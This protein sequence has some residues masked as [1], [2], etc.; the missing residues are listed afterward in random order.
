M[1][2]FSFRL[3]TV[4]EHAHEVE[5]E[6]QLHLARL[7]QQ[8]QRIEERMQIVNLKRE[9]L[10]GAMARIQRNRF[11]AREVAECHLCLEQQGNILVGLKQESDQIDRGINV[12]RQALLEAIKHRQMMEKLREKHLQIHRQAVEKYEL[13]TMEEATV[14]RIARE[15]QARAR[16]SESA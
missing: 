9:E 6:R 3:Q 4:L 11:D 13:K 2:A 7:C 1:K 10:L 14:P 5:E 8:K 15:C 16:W 12:A